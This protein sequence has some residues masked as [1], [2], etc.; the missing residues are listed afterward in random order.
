[1]S[2]RIGSCVFQVAGKVAKKV[3]GSSA[4]PVTALAFAALAFAGT[5]SAQNL[6]FMHSSPIT[7]MRDKDVASLQQALHTALDNNADGQSSEWT[8]EGLGNPVPIKA[9][10]TPKDNAD[11]KGMH[12]RHATV[13]VTAKSQDQSWL[14]L[15][16]KTAQGWKMERQ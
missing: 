10:I 1:M 4:R 7:F 2:S 11:E 9:T 13:T 6:G 15:F 8:N 3:T 5:A 12:C 14:P 16:C